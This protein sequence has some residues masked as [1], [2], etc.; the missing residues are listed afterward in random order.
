MSLRCRGKI[1]IEN[2]KLIKRGLIQLRD[3]H[4]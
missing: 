2:V 1:N 3:D 4:D